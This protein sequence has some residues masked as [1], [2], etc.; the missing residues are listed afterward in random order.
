[1]RKKMMVWTLALGCFIVA[2]G[3][4][5]AGAGEKPATAEATKP[6]VAE[7]A[8]AAVTDPAKPAEPATAAIPAAPAKK[9]AAKKKIE[10]C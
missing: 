3:L 10:G 7:P 2:N 9:P 8:K 1:M 4:A 5:L 6:A